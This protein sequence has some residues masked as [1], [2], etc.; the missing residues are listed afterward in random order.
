[1]PLPLIPIALGVASAATAFFGAKKGVD[2]KKSLDRANTD[3]KHAQG[4]FEEAKTYVEER[5]ASTNAGLQDLGRLRLKTDAGLLK[6]YVELVSAVH[7]VSHK[8]I[9]GGTLSVD[10]SMP[11]FDD[12]KVSAYQASDML[13]DGVAAVP[14]GVLTGVGAAGTVSML[15]AASTG[16]A[17]ASLSGVAAS[18]ATLAWLGGGS[19]AA[20]GWGVAGGTAVLGGVAL[21]PVV[22]VMGLAAASK[23]NKQTTEVRSKEAEYQ[24]ATE[25]LHNAVV[26]LQ[27]IDAR[28]AEVSESIGKIAARFKPSL[29][30]LHQLISAKQQLR[31]ELERQ[32]QQLRDEAARRSWLV[33][34]WRF[35]TGKRDDFSYPD[36][37]D[38]ETF[39]GAE[40]QVYMLA[41]AFAYPLYAL[42]KVPVLD[43]EGAVSPASAECVAN[44]QVLLLKG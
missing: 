10:T 39:S 27:A 38:F 18:N 19:L 32:A 23:M 24:V 17:I 41:S 22:A 16:T 37:L 14:V 20:G 28:V 15:G 13:K 43:D 31:V 6:T 25:Q 11:T 21:G 33:K 35:L 5:K 4:E 30:K 9:S 3:L 12:M 44:A 26:V 42:L 29:A 40:K 1:M 7:N 2:A 8:A 34:L 36:P